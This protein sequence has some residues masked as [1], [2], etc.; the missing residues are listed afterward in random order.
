MSAA[1]QQEIVDAYVEHNIPQKEI[2]KRYR[3]TPLLV[4]NLVND[5]IKKPEKLRE[6]KER[7]KR[8]ARDR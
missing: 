2:A 1:V 4:S 5:A 8:A 7:E 6:K 3:V